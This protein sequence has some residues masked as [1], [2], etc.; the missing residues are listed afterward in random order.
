MAA[1]TMGSFTSVRHYLVCVTGATNDASSNP[2][3]G[4]LESWGK[5]G[6]VGMV[7]T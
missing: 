4:F 1:R 5:C 3:P 6:A 7:W 2:A